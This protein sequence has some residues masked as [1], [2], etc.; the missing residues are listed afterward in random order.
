MKKLIFYVCL[1]IACFFGLNTSI[2]AQQVNR[3]I[4]ISAYIYNFA[5]NI[6]WQ[7]E[8]S[9]NEFHFLIIGHDE[10]ILH[11][12]IT[13]SKTKTIRNKPIRVSSAT[14]LSD[15]NNV[16]LVFATKGNEENL[17]NLFDRIE[18]KNI[19]M[20]SDNYQN[21]QI[22]MINF[23]DSKEGNLL[24]EINKANIINQHLGIMQD[25]IL[26]GGTEI[27]VAELYRE[28]QQSLRTLQ[29][30]TENL[31]NNLVQLKNSISAITKEV[32]INKDS[33][34][35][36]TRKIREQQ[37][38]LNNQSLLL[39]QRE[40]ELD[41]KIQ[42]ISEQRRVF[43]QQSEKL[44]TL[45]ADVNEG[46]QLLLRQRKEI[47]SQEYQ[48]K[49]QTDI[50][51]TQS[52]TIHRQR[53][54]MYLLA[55]ITILVIFLVLTIYYAL[56]NKQK[57]NRELKQKVNERTYEL[58]LLNEQLRVELD[59]RLLAQ[60][61]IKI[62]NQTL[63]E[64]VAERTAQLAS[65]NKELESF[66]YSISH[67]LRAPLRAIFGFS[68]ILANRHRASLNEEGQQYMNYIVQASVR[69][70][71]LINDLLDYSRLGRKSIDIYPV[72]LNKIID[73]IYSDFKQKLENVGA[74]FF[75][76]KEIPEIYGN[77]SLLQQIFTNLIDNAVIYRR[78]DEPLEIKINYDQD[79]KGITLKISDNGIGIPEEYWDK[80]FN[81]FQR[82]HS[83][84]EYPG[85]GIGL[86]TVRKSVSMLNGAI[87]VESV[88]DKGT[89]FFIHLPKSKI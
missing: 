62:L 25:M 67:D 72:S 2:R 51:K 57:H 65:I 8:D 71:H 76:D 13:L 77:E 26:L 42:Q 4:A 16:Q 55:I 41:I 74:T 85:T 9:I 39:N 17:V 83:E 52:S 73:N 37:R 78:K 59:E 54:L 20:V 56:K 22:V 7:N 40:K 63:E 34:S 75:V 47:E 35:R 27:D 1:S 15:I 43:D 48:I 81:I 33:L 86:A 60:E 87:W 61:E 80:I 45:S 3:E 30:H 14:T 19:L 84:D 5:K 32:E 38:I 10:N 23:I 28:G 70:E 53:N 66:S 50:L 49:N 82:L 69:M 58:S 79:A 31:E 88:V 24:F 12:L 44:R 68:Q 11:E 18:G 6:Q 21:K 29:K 89:T 64:R 46:S 36:Q